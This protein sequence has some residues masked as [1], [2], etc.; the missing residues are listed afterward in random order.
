MTLTIFRGHEQVLGE[1]VAHWK[2][3]MAGA[4]VEGVQILLNCETVFSTCAEPV[5]AR[6]TNA[7]AAMRSTA[8]V[9][10]STSGSTGR[11]AP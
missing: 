10:G 4:E 3:R 2:G 6:S 5:S 7:F 1:T 11:P 8:V 9:A